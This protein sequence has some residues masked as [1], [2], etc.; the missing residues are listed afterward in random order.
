VG[1]TAAPATPCPA[2]GRTT[3]TTVGG[4]CTNC[5]RTKAAVPGPPVARETW[6]DLLRLAGRNL[7]HAFI[8]L[9]AAATVALLA[10]ASLSTALAALV[11]IG[12]L[13]LAASAIG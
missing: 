9:A 7:P 5:A 13:Y 10:L 8:A 6:T 12:L 2:C 3:T 1:T 4:H 11:V